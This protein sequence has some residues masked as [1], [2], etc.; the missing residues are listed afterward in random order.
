MDKNTENIILGLHPLEITVLPYLK[1]YSDFDEIVKVSK[2]KDIE[3][4]RA[5]QWL[6]NKE[7]LKINE[8]TKDVIFLDE[9]G[10]KYAKEDLPEVRFLNAIEGETDIDSIIKKSKISQNEV[11]I[12]I[13][14]LKK[15]FAVTITKDAKGR[16]IFSLTSNGEKLK[17]QKNHLNEFLKKSFPVDFSY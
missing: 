5:I 16:M 15:V 11:S 13:G 12:C 1:I 2:L 9:N 10:K 14:E 17:K 3:V 7:L 8:E 6:S 4:M